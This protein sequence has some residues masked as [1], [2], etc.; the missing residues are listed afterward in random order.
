MSSFTTRE[1]H[2]RRKLRCL[3]VEKETFSRAMPGNYL[4]R[5]LRMQGHCIMN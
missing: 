2:T 4:I 5:E 3:I 1:T